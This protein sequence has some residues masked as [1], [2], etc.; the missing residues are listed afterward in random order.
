MLQ[1]TASSHIG[2]FHA[3]DTHE[4]VHKIRKCVLSGS[5]LRKGSLNDLDIFAQHHLAS[6]T[7]SS[8]T[9]GVILPEKCGLLIARPPLNGL[10]FIVHVGASGNISETLVS[11]VLA[12][13]RCIRLNEHVAEDNSGCT[14]QHRYI[15]SY[16]SLHAPTVERAR[17]PGLISLYPVAR[18]DTTGCGLCIE[19]WGSG[20]LYVWLYCVSASASSSALFLYSYKR[21]ETTRSKEAKWL[22]FS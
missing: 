7:T 13:E 15:T 17:V 10:V 6:K 2:S 21:G 16:P 4:R 14:K 12:S 11:A 1:Q 19:T 9:Y 3:E 20:V 5:D 22:A 18:A 8:T